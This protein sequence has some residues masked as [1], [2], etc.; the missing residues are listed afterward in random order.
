[1]LLELSLQKGPIG[2]RSGQAVTDLPVLSAFKSISE[3]NNDSN[4]NNSHHSNHSNNKQLLQHSLRRVH[5]KGRASISLF[6]ARPLKLYSVNNTLRLRFLFWWSQ[7][8]ILTM[9]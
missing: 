2:V 1:M 8:P 4:S 5:G 3:N 7:W 9:P 6:L